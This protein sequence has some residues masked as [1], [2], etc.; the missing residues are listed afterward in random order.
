MAKCFYCGQMPLMTARTGLTLIGKNHVCPDC[1]SERYVRCP[2]CGQ[3]A[4]SEAMKT[5]RLNYPSRNLLTRTSNAVPGQAT[6]AA[7]LLFFLFQFKALNLD[8]ILKHTDGESNPFR[9]CVNLH[10]DTFCRR[11]YASIYKL[12]LHIRMHLQDSN[13]RTLPIDNAMLQSYQRGL[14]LYAL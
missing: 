8:Y 6:L 1:I 9:N 7:I 12:N 14:R 3:Y 10:P 5:K 13:L 4:L 11:Q 2:D